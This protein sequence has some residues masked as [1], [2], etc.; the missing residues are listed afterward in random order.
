M[1]GNIKNVVF[2]LGGVLVDWNPRHLYRKIF[3]D[4]NEMEWFLD[5]VCSPEWNL[6]QDGGRPFSV[7]ISEL[8]A[9]YPE[10]SDKIAL[11]FDRWEEMLGGELVGT[12][13][14]LEELKSK[15]TPIYGLTNWSNETFP[16]A[17]SKYD[18][19]KKLQGI[20][21]SGDEKLLK[22]DPAIYRLL[23]ERYKIKPSE[24]V[25]IDDNKVNAEASAGLGF[26]YIH[27]TTSQDLRT[28]LR[29]LGLDV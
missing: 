6:M 24:S 23:I 18:C 29:D 25:Y 14:I 3:I 16:I 4:E 2:D 5:E 17:F 7:A 27:F 26:N 15:G 13:E 9:Q 8:S 12:V 28:R 1:M 22:P 20:V 19:L 11:Y 21:V 10:L